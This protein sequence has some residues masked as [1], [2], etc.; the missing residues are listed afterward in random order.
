MNHLAEKM[1]ADGI[2]VEEYNSKDGTLIAKNPYNQ[3]TKKRQLNN[4]RSHQ[5]L[6][7]IYYPNTITNENFL[8]QQRPRST[9]TINFSGIEV[10][11]INYNEVKKVN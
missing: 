7:S 8:N 11:S 6:N 10:N 3:T 5:N 4:N 9:N 1:A 2:L